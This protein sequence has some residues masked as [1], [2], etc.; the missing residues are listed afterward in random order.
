MLKLNSK[1]ME[2]NFDFERNY[3]IFYF[4]WFESFVSDVCEVAKIKW[5]VFQELW[6]INYNHKRLY[7]CFNIQIRNFICR[8]I[9]WVYDF[10]E[11]ANYP[12]KIII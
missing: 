1:M 8:F 7:I 3:E 4:F 5:I 2:D 11:K 12:K 10:R 6:I 9:N